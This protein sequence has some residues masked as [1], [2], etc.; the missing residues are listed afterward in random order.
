MLFLKEKKKNKIEIMRKNFRDSKY[1]EMPRNE[2]KIRIPEIG[3]MK[4]KGKKS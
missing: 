3:S 2:N 4:P 1:K